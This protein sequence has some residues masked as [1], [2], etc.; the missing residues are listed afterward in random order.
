[1]AGGTRTGS[2]GAVG[3]SG[4]ERCRGAN[5]REGAG[6]LGQ[7]RGGDGHTAPGVTIGFGAKCLEALR[8]LGDVGL[9]FRQP[10]GQLRACRIWIKWALFKCS[11]SV[12]TGGF[13]FFLSVLKDNDFSEGGARRPNAFGS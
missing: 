1:M 9:L 8:E 2:R 12:K 7:A 10:H 5:T 6:S 11:E 13:F 3:G 4:G